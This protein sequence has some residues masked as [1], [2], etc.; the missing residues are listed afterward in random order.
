M[1]R[2][3]VI[4]ALAGGALFAGNE[5]PKIDP[6]IVKR[7]DEGV[8]TALSRQITDPNSRGCGTLPDGS[9]LYSAHAAAGLLESFM[10]ACLY[11]QSKFHESTL[12][13]DRIKLAAGYLD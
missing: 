5:I 1:D 3:Q 2:R 10:A 11:P 13:I 4:T 12:L 8:D 6:G 9:G 7:H